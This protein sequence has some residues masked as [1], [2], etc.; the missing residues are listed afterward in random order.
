MLMVVGQAGEQEHQMQLKFAS[1]GEHC[2]MK[3]KCLLWQL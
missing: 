2:L 3:D 1:V